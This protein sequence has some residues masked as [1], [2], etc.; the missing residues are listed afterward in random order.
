M[1][2]NW[3]TR[4]EKEERFSDESAIYMR[5]CATESR[6]RGICHCMDGV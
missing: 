6:G 2:D 3:K 4:L 5:G 1:Y